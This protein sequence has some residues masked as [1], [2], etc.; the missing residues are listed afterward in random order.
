MNRLLSVN[1]YHYRRGGSDI[2]YLDHAALFERHGWSNVFFS[3]AHP[4]NQPYALDRHFA[5]RVDYEVAKGAVDRL[6][7][8]SRIIYSREA[9]R[10]LAALLDEHPVD[11]AHL[12]IIHHHLSPSVLVEL[13]RRGIPAVMTAHDLK[14]ACPSYKMMNAGGVCE[15]CKGGRV[16]NV[17]RHRCIKGS[18]PASGLIMVESALHKLF[19]VYA[20]TLSAV[21]APSRFYRAKL[22]EWGWR[23][24]QVHYVPNCVALPPAAPGRFGD[25][26]LFFGRLAPEKGVATLIAAAAKS[27]VPVV[28]VGSGPEEA[29]LRA[30]AASLAAPVTFRGFLSGEP[31]WQ[32]VERCRAVVLPSEWYENAPVSVLEAFARYRPVAGAAIGGI[33]ELIT[34]GVTGWHFRSG[35]VGALAETLSAIADAPEPQLVAMGQAA[36]AFVAETFSEERYFTAMSTLYRGLLS[37]Q[38]QRVGTAAGD[39]LQGAEAGLGFASGQL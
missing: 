7:D 37:S 35:D 32:E 26:V 29:A 5:A 38:G 28:I 9:Q 39:R 36:R 24:E 14:L 19:D 18:L 17:V 20:K 4:N 12:H 30:L 22:I 23:P 3:M 16:W 27:R 8:A 2:V 10:R 11:L 15:R 21:V 25:H 33:P 6:V 1:S 13:R 34:Q 31:L